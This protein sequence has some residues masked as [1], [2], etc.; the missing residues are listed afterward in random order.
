MKKFKFFKDEKTAIINL[1]DYWETRTDTL[2]LTENTNNL[3]YMFRPNR[4]DNYE[5]CFQF[6]DNE[7]VRFADG[8]NNLN[9][10]ISPTRDGSIIFNDNGR[11]FKIFAREI[12]NES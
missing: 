12:N 2:N 4:V 9:I 5:F 8:S 10:N 7:P 3:V 1:N 11:R 6:D